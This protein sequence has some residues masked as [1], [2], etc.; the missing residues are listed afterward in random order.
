M[1]ESC[2]EFYDS[3]NYYNEQLNSSF[4]DF[5]EVSKDLENYQRGFLA[6]VKYYIKVAKGCGY[7]IVLIYLG[8]L[9]LI[10]FFGC[11][12]LLAYSYMKN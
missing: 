5:K 1:K 8:I 3:G 7:I 2:L 6:K 11:L 12:L 10:L 9:C 4:N